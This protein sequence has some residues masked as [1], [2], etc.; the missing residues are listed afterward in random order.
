[1]K[2]AIAAI[3]FGTSFTAAAIRRDNAMRLVDFGRG[4]RIESGVIWGEQEGK[5]VAGRAAW[6]RRK[7]APWLF[8]P[9]PK[10]LIEQPDYL[11]GNRLVSVRSMI[12]AVLEHALRELQRSLVDPPAELRLTHPVAWSDSRK[13]LLLG[14]GR[15][16]LTQVGWRDVAVQLLPEP[17]AAAVE[18]ASENSVDTGS[19]LAIYDLGGGTFDAA[20]VRCTDAGFE[21]VGASRGLDPC[22]GEDFDEQILG[23]VRRTLEARD[24]TWAQMFEPDEESDEARRRRLDFN[25][26]L[27]EAIV[28]AK[29]TLSESM[30]ADVHSRPMDASAA[31]TREQFERLI[32]PAVVRTIRTLQDTI[33]EAID[34]N[35]MR[36]EEL[37]GIV[38]TGGSSRIPLVERLIKERFALTVFTQ[39]DRKGTVALG[40]V[41]WTPDARV[42]T[43]SAAGRRRSESQTF[44]VQ[45]AVEFRSRLGVK[46]DSNWRNRE[47]RIVV[48]SEDLIVN[49]Y[50][51]SLKSNDH[52]ASSVRKN[53]TPSV[54]VG[55]VL[56][57]RVAGVE[58]GV[59]LWRLES[60]EDGTATKYLERFALQRV[61]GG[62]R[63]AHI[64][65]REGAEDLVNHV[66]IGD[67]LLSSTEYEHTPFVL[68]VPAGTQV[69][70]RT[71]IEPRRRLGGRAS[72][73]VAAESTDLAP[74]ASPDEWA[75]RVLARFSAEA[76]ES[77]LQE[78]DSFLGGRPGTRSIVKLKAP[79]RSSG[80]KW[81]CW[82]TGVV[83]GRGVAIAVEAPSPV[84]V[85]KAARYR[86]LF[87]L[88]SP[89]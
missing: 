87:V 30:Q 14:A 22:G 57:A 26:S 44:A 18:A 85:D 7:A 31:I 34:G 65:A 68:R 3:D 41:R 74:D 81:G 51:S 33:Q 61:N 52:W 83:D 37:T 40:A 54:A 89:A 21:I 35:S 66:H 2:T 77:L 29:E 23:L 16:T 56:P 59:Q 24:D 25:L 69:W 20:T 27:R 11:L 6:T 45:P 28:E 62:V 70:E 48:G 43:T 49:G 32:E 53:A 64:V 12:E 46:V 82:W 60:H 73:N 39:P 38:L 86:D 15:H 9:T 88:G 55:K 36:A 75:A 5:L 79:L 84:S 50:P 80:V 76:L 72:F 67:P 4:P 8:V 42:K 58:E 78:E 13:E 47:M 10:R 19:V 63:A 71:T 1:M 17:V